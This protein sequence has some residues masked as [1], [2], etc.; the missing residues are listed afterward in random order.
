MSQNCYEHCR[1]YIQQCWLCC[2]ENIHDC[3]CGAQTHDI[4]A[5]CTA[6]RTFVNNSWD[7]CFGICLGWCATLRAKIVEHT[8]AAGLLL[9][10]LLAQFAYPKRQQQKQEWMTGTC[11]DKSCA[12]SYMPACLVM[13]N[14][15]AC[16]RLTDCAA[17]V[18][19]NSQPCRCHR[20]A[21]LSMQETRKSHSGQPRCHKTRSSESQRGMSCIF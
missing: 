17:T 8:I 20:T 5:I 18:Y 16:V 3:Y 1:H 19:L 7:S 9:Y 12:P 11:S 2:L 6:G 13:Q 14:R 4:A 10:M 15:L 21:L